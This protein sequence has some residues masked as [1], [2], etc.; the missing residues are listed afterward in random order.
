MSERKM[1]ANTFNKG[2]QMDVNPMNTPNDVMTSCLNGTLL[3]YN[4]NEFMLQT[5]MGN[6]R[7]ET[8]YLPEGYIPLGIVEF[9]GII[10]VA[11]YNP[12][13]D[14]SQIG[15]FPSPERNI[16]TEELNKNV[17]SISNA[18]FGFNDKNN[19]ASVFYVQKN[20]YEEKLTPGDKFIVY[21][22]LESITGN[23]G[24][25]FDFPIGQ[26][27]FEN[28]ATKCVEL[29]FATITNEGKIVR[30]AN[31]KEYKI[32][33]TDKKY[34]IPEIS[35]N[36]DSPILDSYRSIVSSPYNIF[37]S[38]VSGK[39]L[40]IAELVTI[41]EFNV[42]ISC[43][44]EGKDTADTK[45]VHITS[46]LS[47]SSKNNVF[48][49]GVKGNVI[50]SINGKFEKSFLWDRLSVESNEQIKEN[51]ECSALLHTVEGYDYKNRP[52]HNIK[53][54]ITPCMPFGPINYLMRSG[55][56]QLDKIGTGYIE[57]YEWRY[58]VDNSNIMINWALQSYPEEGYMIA[59][60]KFIMSCYNK[61]GA[62]ETCVYNVS[63]KTS[64]NG[65]FV[66]NIPFDSEYYKI[67]E[68]KLLKNRLYFITIEVQYTKELNGDT[69][70]YKYFHKWLYTNE[71]FNKY[72]IEGKLFDFSKIEP[73]L[74]ISAESSFEFKQKENTIKDTKYGK[75]NV[76]INEAGGLTPLDSLSAAKYY[77]KYSLSFKVDNSFTDN[78]GVFDIDKSTVR[79]TI[80]INK[81]DS[82]IKF[83][84][85]GIK[86]TFGDIPI[87]AEDALKLIQNKNYDGSNTQ[88][89][90]NARDLA[91][92]KYNHGISFDN[93]DT[94]LN[95]DNSIIDNIDVSIIEYVKVL[96][97][98][99]KKTVRWKGELKPFVY[100]SDSYSRYNLVYDEASRSFRT[101]FLGSWSTRSEHSRG[102]H[103]PR[104]AVG[105]LLAPEGETNYEIFRKHGDH[106][107]FDDD[108]YN[109]FEGCWTTGFASTIIFSAWAQGAGKYWANLVKST[110]SINNNWS[111]KDDDNYVCGIGSDTNISDTCGIFVF[112][113]TKSDGRYAPINMCC[114]FDKQRDYSDMKFEKDIFGIRNIYTCIATML[115]QLYFFDSLGGTEERMIPSAIY[116]R[117]RIISDFTINANVHVDTSNIKIKVYTDNDSVIYID[118]TM[119]QNLYNNNNS[120]AKNKQLDII[121]NNET[122]EN[123]TVEIDSNDIVTSGSLQTLRDSSELIDYISISAEA[124]YNCRIYTSWGDVQNSMDVMNNET[125]YTVS[126]D[127]AVSKITS[128][129][130]LK[131]CNFRSENGMIYADITDQDLSSNGEFL[132]ALSIDN[133]MIVLDDMNGETQNQMRTTSFRIDGRNMDN[134]ENYKGFSKFA[135]ISK[136]KFFNK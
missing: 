21:T 14:K 49:Y 10:Y 1:A 129:F 88:F 15:S 116:Y 31:L 118:E 87:I 62:I 8:A 9:G 105:R 96:T 66:E 26:P 114:R 5:D 75:T 16:S 48:L 61:K 20:L 93:I 38:K 23:E 50:D 128:S 17:V 111:Y 103:R 89:P 58:Y 13:I 110:N 134:G 68:G 100:D 60:V 56:I 37:N 45:D 98:L 63:K 47:Y 64:Y 127:I 18:D 136:L 71:I 102:G 99:T 133:G 106:C 76:S 104:T 24:K 69:S 113:K 72:Y 131:K 124:E 35:Y 40:L 117:D 123:I 6:G 54:E 121:L 42:S 91:N 36:G 119:K 19:G 41:D 81:E 107:F 53:Y 44:F 126:K 27:N 39:L 55:I 3:T 12:F 46:N 115:S 122:D 109:G 4:G 101:K 83:D 74:S 86:S 73:L 43:E 67:A 94:T 97:Q 120:K 51:R 7:V 2:L 108:L 59:G 82:I 65:S 77:T 84:D 85:N 90:D 30:L 112:M 80:K 125:I 32:N 70:R 135:P 34:I 78:Y 130:K 29:Y 92:E 79:N 22:K 57:L 11:S 28:G 25:L 132:R 33:G 95:G 52:I